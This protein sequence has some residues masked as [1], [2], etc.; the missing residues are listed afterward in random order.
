MAGRI[1]LGLRF[2]APESLDQLGSHHPQL[3]LAPL[4]RPTI[5]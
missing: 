3:G 5:S 1:R 2:E 4:R